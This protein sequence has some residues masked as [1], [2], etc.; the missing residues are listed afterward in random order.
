MKL[1]HDTKYLSYKLYESLISKIDLRY[2]KNSSFRNAEMLAYTH[3]CVHE[4]NSMP[5]VKWER[6]YPNKVW[7]HYVYLVMNNLNKYMK[8]KYF[9]DVSLNYFSPMSYIS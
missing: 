2:F 4:S 8:H 9:S 7:I 3:T 5:N 6:G 1:S